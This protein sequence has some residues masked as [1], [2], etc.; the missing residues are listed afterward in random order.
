MYSKYDNIHMN[1][2]FYAL[3]CI[4][5]H[6]NTSIS[7]ILSSTWIDSLKLLKRAEIHAID[8]TKIN[9]RQKGLDCIM[10]KAK[11]IIIKRSKPL[12]AYI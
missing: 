3:I 6:I 11:F 1:R 5:N 9:E 10:C 4:H 8:W 2:M 7:C 12:I